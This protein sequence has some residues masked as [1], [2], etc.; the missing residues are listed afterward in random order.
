MWVKHCIR[1]IYDYYY[2]LETGQGTWEE[3][4]GFE[5]TAGQLS[6]EDIQV[7]LY[8][9][10]S[11]R[12]LKLPIINL[13]RVQWTMTVLLLGLTGFVFP[14]CQNVVSCVTAEYNRKQ[15]WLA[16]ESFIIQL[17]ARGRGYLV[18]KKHT[19]RMEYLRQQEPSVVKIQVWLLKEH[20]LIYWLSRHM[21]F[22][23]RSRLHRVAL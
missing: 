9:Y 20:E 2:N 6:K 17:Q 8:I 22:I 1:G 21:N 19:E 23:N 14:L 3:P 5:P 11:T 12:R 16:N 18:R 15:L 4:E 13:I 7:L 10:H